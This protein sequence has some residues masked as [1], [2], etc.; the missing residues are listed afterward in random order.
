M[1]LAARLRLTSRTIL[2]RADGHLSVSA[3]DHG[4]IGGLLK[5]TCGALPS[6]LANE[7]VDAVDAGGFLLFRGFFLGLGRSLGCG[8]AIKEQLGNVSQGLRNKTLPR[9]VCKVTHR[10][11]YVRSKTKKEKNTWKPN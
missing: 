6:L 8:E 2:A 7:G 1:S 10:I 4:A 9:E 3:N 11:R 5:A